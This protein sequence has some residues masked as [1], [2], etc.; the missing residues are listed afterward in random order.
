MSEKH[1]QNENHYLMVDLSKKSVEI[2]IEYESEAISTIYIWNELNRHRLGQQG[3][4]C[5]VLHSKCTSKISKGGKNEDIFQ[6]RSNLTTEKKVIKSQNGLDFLVF[7]K[8]SSIFPQ[9]FN[10][11]V[12]INEFFVSKMIKISR[13]QPP[14]II[15]NRSNYLSRPFHSR[16]FGS[17]R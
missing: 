10:R 14:K 12:K 1:K 17:R 2:H 9:N 3:V 6:L 15:K 5:V 11:F 4:L 7:W 16:I 13:T 8:I